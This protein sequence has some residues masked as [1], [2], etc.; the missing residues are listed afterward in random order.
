MAETFTADTRY[1]CGWSFEDDCVSCLGKINDQ[2]RTTFQH[3]VNVAAEI[4][5]A[6]S[7]RQFGLC[8]LTIRPCRLE[9]C[10]PCNMSGFRWT[11]VLA[12]GEWHNVSCGKCKT[13]CYCSEVCDLALP[14]PIEKVIE[15]KVDGVVIPPTG[16]SVDHRRLLTRLGGECWPKCQDMNLDDDQPNTYSVTY[17][18]GKPLPEGARRAL[19]EL[20]CE[21]FLDCI[22]DDCCKLPKRTTS[23]SRPG[24][25]MAMIDPMDFIPKGKTGL[26]AVDLW[27]QSVNPT[28]RPRPS[29]ILSPDMAK[30]RRTT[31]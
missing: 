9:G 18:R 24:V 6:L 4:L 11:P 5:Y 10:D 25:T 19:A 30:H 31:S 12:G 28:A 2:N 3:A 13:S 1:A 27:L 8:E 21:L 14:G 23:I 26:Y 15:V 17:L 29:A 20:A 22:D 7:G 16:Y